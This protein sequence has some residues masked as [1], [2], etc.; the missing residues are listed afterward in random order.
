[1]RERLPQFEYVPLLTR[2]GEQRRIDAAVLRDAVGADVL[3]DFAVRSRVQ[4]YM[5]GPAQLQRM[6]ADTLVQ[7]L[8][9][10]ES[11]LHADSFEF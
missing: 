5:C 2:E 1:M 10:P 3:A 7:G 4:V 9:L 6:V 11:N 8:G